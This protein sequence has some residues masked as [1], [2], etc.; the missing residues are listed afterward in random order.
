MPAPKLTPEQ[1]ADLRAK[2]QQAQPRGFWS[3]QGRALG[4]SR[5]NICQ[6]IKGR[7]HNPRPAEWNPEAFD[8]RSYA[9]RIL[10]K[11]TAA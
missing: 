1:I 2:A 5:T 6:I 9:A 4:V 11:L 3:A 8:P 7:R 10:A